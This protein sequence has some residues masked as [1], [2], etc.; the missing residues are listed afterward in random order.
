MTAA[1]FEVRQTVMVRPDVPGDSL[2]YGLVG[3]WGRVASIDAAKDRV[4][5]VFINGLG[6]W[7]VPARYL[8]LM[9]DADA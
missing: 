2:L 7:W 6:P 5:V 8:E 1:E 3:T 9:P 4:E